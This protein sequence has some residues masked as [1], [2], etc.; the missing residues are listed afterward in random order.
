MARRRPRP[1]PDQRPGNAH[2]PRGLFGAA[3]NGDGNHC[4]DREF[5]PRAP[6]REPNRRPPA[7]RGSDRI[8]TDGDV[9]DDPRLRRAGSRMGADGRPANVDAQHT[10]LTMRAVGLAHW[11][12]RSLALWLLVLLG[13]ACH[14]SG[15]V[16]DRAAE[17][18]WNGELTLRVVNHSWLD[19]TIYLVQGTR[20]DR[21]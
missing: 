15:N 20:R 12:R 3:R 18:S 10:E 7:A 5:C 9:G 13:T 6:L 8:T 11:L 4:L 19:V 21:I 14:H 2:D 17:N 16:G 1:P